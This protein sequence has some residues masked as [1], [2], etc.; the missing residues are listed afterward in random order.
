MRFRVFVVAAAL[1]VAALGLV[2]VAPKTASAASE[3]PAH[4][5][6]SA[7]SDEICT[8]AYPTR[9]RGVGTLPDRA[10]SPR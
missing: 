2:A 4:S 9:A 3:A 8:W 10:T 6:I 7:H 5:A 1:A